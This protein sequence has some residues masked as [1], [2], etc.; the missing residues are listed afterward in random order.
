LLE[1]INILNVKLKR[2]NAALLVATEASAPIQTPVKDSIIV[3]HDSVIIATKCINYTTPYFHLEGCVIDSNM[4]EGF[5]EHIDTLVVVE[6]RV[7]KRFLFIKFG[8]KL[9]RTDFLTRNPA[10]RL[11]EILSITVVD[12]KGKRKDR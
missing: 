2:V 4:F 5:Y 6:H 7:P 9:V 10:T 12:K 1:Q 11:N 8:T 3:V